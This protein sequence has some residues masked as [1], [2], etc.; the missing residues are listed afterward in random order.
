MPAA[1]ID[2]PICAYQFGGDEPRAC[3]SCPVNRSCTLLCCPNCG[4]NTV[5]P[6]QSRAARGLLR[7]LRRAERRRFEPGRAPAGATPAN[8]DARLNEPSAERRPDRPEPSPVTLRDLPPGSRARVCEFATDA[9]TRCREALIAYGLCPGQWLWVR[10]NSPV[11]VVE[12]DQLELALDP[13]LAQW[14]EIDRLECPL[15]DSEPAS[16]RI[17]S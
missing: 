9:P 1:T 17:L 12:V 4:H 5:D 6:G 14:I 13:D 3:A 7:L 16:Q 15:P 10:R 11:T 2:C 8:R